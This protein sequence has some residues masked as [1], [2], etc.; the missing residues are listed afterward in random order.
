MFWRLSP[1]CHHYFLSPTKM[2]DGNTNYVSAFIS[3]FIVQRHTPWFLFGMT[4]VVTENIVHTLPHVVEKQALHFCSV[5]INSV[6]KVNDR[7]FNCPGKSIYCRKNNRT[8]SF[9][10]ILNHPRQWRIQIHAGRQQYNIHSQF[11]IIFLPTRAS[12]NRNGQKNRKIGI[13]APKK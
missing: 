10:W 6:W 5:Q 13:R 7:Y 3:Y 11:K 9:F 8:C 2:F 1:H 12:S 4:H